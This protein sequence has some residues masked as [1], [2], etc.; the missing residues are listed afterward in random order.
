MG[1]LL[2]FI[3][4]VLF[5]IIFIIE[6]LVMLFIKVKNRKWFKLSEQRKFVKARRTD[7]LGNFLFADLFNAILSK[8]G[9]QFGRLGETLSSVFGKK[10]KEKSLN[11]FGYGIS[12]I[13]DFVD[14]TKWKKG[15][16]CQWSIMSNKE[17]EFF[18]SKT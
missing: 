8:G 6:D 12:I 16:H 3:S 17:I 7:I 18:L 15:G 11:W 2:S 13:I 4:L 1:F 10:R 9:Y 14:F 5:V